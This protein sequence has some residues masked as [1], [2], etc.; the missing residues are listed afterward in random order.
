[1]KDV[2]CQ[3]LGVFKLQSFA[4]DDDDEVLRWFVETDNV[5]AQLDAIEVIVKLATIWRSHYSDIPKSEIVKA[6][7][8]LNARMAEAAFGYRIEGG[9]IVSLSDEFTHSELVV[10]AIRLLHAPEFEAAQNEFLEAHASLRNQD[11]E[12]AIHECAKSL[13]STLKVIAKARGWAG[14]NDSSNIKNLIAAAFTAGL[15]EPYMEA[16]TNALRALIE[17]S[18]PTIRNKSGGHGAGSEPRAVPEYLARFQL[19]QTAAVIRML[20]EAHQHAPSIR[21]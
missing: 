14:V 1:M 8:I 12:A 19:H 15:L 2:L 10:P 16:S 20:A 5:D 3:E 6:V 9:L 17:S 11:F 4:Q 18:V 7:D 13:E 21:L